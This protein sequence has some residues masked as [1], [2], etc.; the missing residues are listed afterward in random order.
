MRLLRKSILMVFIMG[1]FPFPYIKT[2]AE[3]S[4]QHSIDDAVTLMY[5]SDA[6]LLDES[7]IEDSPDAIGM[8]SPTQKGKEDVDTNP[9]LARFIHAKK[10]Q[11]NDPDA[12]CQLLKAYYIGQG[13]HCETKEVN[14]YCQ[15]TRGEINSQIGFFD[16][17]LLEKH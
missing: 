16:M 14:N 17:Y 1:L 10:M 9:L 6:V 2:Q 8:L 15:K 12:N 5:I 11:R 3:E 13:K 4:I 7:E